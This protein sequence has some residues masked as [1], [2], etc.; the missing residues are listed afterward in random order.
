LSY[1][2]KREEMAGKLAGNHSGMYGVQSWKYEELSYRNME[3][4]KAYIR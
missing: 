2:R 4:T 3:G 1:G